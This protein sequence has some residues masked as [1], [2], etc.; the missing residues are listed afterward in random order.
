LKQFF[1][2]PRYWFWFTTKWDDFEDIPF[3]QD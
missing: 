3:L 1:R 2:R